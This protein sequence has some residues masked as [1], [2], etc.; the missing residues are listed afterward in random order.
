M[1]H[2]LRKVPQSLALFLAKEFLQTWVWPFAITAGGVVIGWLEQASFFL[3]YV[4]AVVL[5]ASSAAGMLRF[6]EW[7]FRNRVADKL[8]FANM[9]IGG[10][11]D[12]NEGRLVALRFGFNLSNRATFPIRFRI[13]EMQTSMTDQNGARSFYPP[14]R[15]YAKNEISV[16]PNV[17]GW[18]E[19][20]NILIPSDLRGSVVALIVCK[21]V[22]GKG[23]R[24][25]HIL[26]IKK[27][28]VLQFNEKGMSGGENWYDQ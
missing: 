12:S 13:E 23:E 5:F 24:L 7:R 1:L 17:M 26:Q 20:H 28:A 18:F 4:G 21:V 8:V 11:V 27:K 10:H 6:S 3:L 22:Y 19:D 15:E 14:R 9:R 2:W 16:S 25:D